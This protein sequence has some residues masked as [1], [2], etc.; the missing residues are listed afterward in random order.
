VQAGQSDS[1]LFKNFTKLQNIHGIKRK[2]D[3]FYFV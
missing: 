3:G 1:T 2:S